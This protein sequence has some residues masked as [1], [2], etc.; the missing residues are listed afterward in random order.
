[1]QT[2][3]ALVAVL[4]TTA[5]TT[6]PDTAGS[7]SQPIIGGETARPADY[8]TV[9]ALEEQPG[10]WF[11]TGTLIARNWVLTA[12]HCV[13]EGPTTGLHARF[14][15][16]DVNDTTGGRVVAISEIHSNPVFD[17]EAWD[18]DI[19]LL[20]L[21]EDVTDREP[22][23][24]LRDPVAFGTA[25]VDVGYGVSDNNEGGGGL[26]R[27]VQKVTAD[28]AGAND[29]GVSGANLVCMDAS[30]GRGSCFGDS[31]GPTFATIGGARVVAGVTSGGTGDLC[32]AGWDLY[33]SVHAELA[34]LDAVMTAPSNPPNPDPTPDPTTPDPTTD[35]SGE[36]D[37]DDADGG[38]SAGGSRGGLAV[39]G[40][41]LA[42]VVRRR[43]A[44]SEI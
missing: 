31:G 4:W 1:M 23:P 41:A 17:W 7:I 29:P 11:C 30:D 3:L 13:A 16:A 10:N 25:V 32:G 39:I 33:T 15:D 26:L 8:P 6:A 5:C 9:V 37:A 18:N 19:A 28:C 21:A 22:T 42:A 2:R 40:L 35:P 44:P 12:A 24:I 43:R 14:D 34:F 38:C 36:G 20:K 27:R